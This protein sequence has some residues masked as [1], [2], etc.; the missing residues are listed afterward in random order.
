MNRE[1]LLSRITIGTAQWGLDYGITNNNPKT[2]SSEAKEILL[3]AKKSGIKKLDTSLHYGDSLSV[4]NST[5]LANDFKITSKIRVNNKINHED[6]ISEFVNNIER[7]FDIL[8]C[9]MLDTL[10]I[11]NGADLGNIDRK[12]W[13]K[14]KEILLTD[15][16]VGAFG[17]SIYSEDEV[18]KYIIEDSQVVQMPG[19]IYDQRYRRLIR[20]KENKRLQVRSILL[21]GLMLCNVEELKTYN[22]E[23]LHQHQRKLI[24]KC[25][26]LHLKPIE[27][28]TLFMLEQREIEDVLIGISEKKEIIELIS[29]CIINREE[30]VYKAFN[31]FE[32][33][34][35]DIIDPRNW[36][37]A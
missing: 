5:N 26:E 21:Q 17:V 19:S 16:R 4:I 28:A 15:K 8:G 12:I 25:E 23:A 27:A 29:S 1:D 22:M 6:C 24:E 2:T 10:L 18:P 37:K 13:E 7:T 3:L 34:E 9:N 31:S 33:D 35:I 20:K 32:V 36:K 14:L 11:H 30:S